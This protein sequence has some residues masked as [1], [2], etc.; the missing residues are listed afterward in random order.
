MRA[1]VT[2][3]LVA[4]MLAGGCRAPESAPSPAASAPA[5]PPAAAPSPAGAVREPAAP[6][7]PPRRLM[8]GLSAVNAI[9][10]PLWVAV[11]EGLFRK[12]GLEVEVANFDGGSRAVA[13]IMTGD[14]PLG[15]INSGSAVDARLQGPDITI[16][17][18]L[19]DTL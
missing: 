19:F 18:G 7:A 10:A 11:D 4:L 5:A 17:A 9:A 2:V 12:E 1:I 3:T 13:A 6:A 16:I 8:V 14:T 15:V